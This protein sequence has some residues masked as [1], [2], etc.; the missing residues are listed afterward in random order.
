MSSTHDTAAAL[1]AE[2][3]ATLRRLADLTHDFDGIVEAARDVATDDEHDPEGQT[4]A[5]ERAQVSMLQDR[6]RARLDELDA[7][8]DRLRAG[9]YGGCEHC[10]RAIPAERLAVRPAATRCVSCAALPR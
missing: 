5:F 3:A 10:G 9:G 2:R 7:A 8:L 4:I 1:L 6:A